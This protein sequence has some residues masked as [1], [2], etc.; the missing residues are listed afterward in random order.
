M[1]SAC[2][3]FYLSGIETF[4]AEFVKEQFRIDQLLANLLL[5]VV[6]GGAILGVLVSGNLSDRLLKRGYPQRSHRGRCGGGPG[7]PPSCS[8]RL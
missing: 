6:G 8:S 5:L 1:A 4:G 3:Y 2:G 7:S